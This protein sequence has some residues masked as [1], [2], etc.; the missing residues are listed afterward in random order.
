[1]DYFTV[2]RNIAFFFATLM[3]IK[4]TVFLLLAP[5]YDVLE[6][7]RKIKTARKYKDEEYLPKISVIIPAWNEEVGIIKTITSVI[8][9]KYQKTEII[10]ISDGSTDKTDEKVEQFI[11]DNTKRGSFE[12]GRIRF[13]QKKNTGKGAT[14]N[15]G[16]KK[17]TGDILLT[18]DAD[19]ALSHDALYNLIEYYKHPEIMAVVGQVRISKSYSL[20]GIIQRLEY[21]FGFY[22][23]RAHAV[24]NAEY[25]FGGAC[26]SF[27]KEVPKK[28]GYFDE[29]NKT[30]DIEYSMRV[31]ASGMK[32]AY[33]ENVVCYTEGADN[34]LGL[35]NQR[36]RWKKG[37]LDTFIR[38]RRLFFST[39]KK[40]NKF[41]SWF[42]LPYAL[43]AEIQLLFEPISIALL[44][45]YS[46]FSGDYVSLS[47]GVMFIFI[48]YIVSSL[49][50]KERVNP[51]ILVLFPFT[52]AFFY[53]LMWV[54]YLALIQG[55]FMI[56]RGKNVQW[57]NWQRKGVSEI[58]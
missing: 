25:I 50:T 39:E 4:Y 11:K 47:L 16:I 52:W 9:N 13:Y 46:I 24:M 41:L 43:L 34:F 45:S 36:L 30:E 56:L 58:S 1:M 53:I 44:I 27:R 22:F 15:F 10:V 33:A 12:N 42:V 51:S 37:R 35:I 20:I 32:S 49:F 54:E 29:N 28:I 48:I 14:L 57:Q 55:A 19:S 21:Y 26:A 40:H 17:A 8:D 3:L 38:Y 18:I 2:F 23:K 5:F 6:L 7:R 31:R